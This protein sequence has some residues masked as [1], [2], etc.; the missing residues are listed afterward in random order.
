MTEN[1]GNS[2]MLWVLRTPTA[3]MHQH[4]FTQTGVHSYPHT[5]GP[6]KEIAFF[7][8]RAHTGV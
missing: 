3:H 7:F 4:R 5:T 1:D 2:L 6:S 8:Y